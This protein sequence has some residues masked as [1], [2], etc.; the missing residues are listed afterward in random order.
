MPP[1]GQDPFLGLIFMETGDTGRGTETPGEEEC[2]ASVA[3]P[4]LHVMILFVSGKIQAK[5]LSS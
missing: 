1:P 2:G 5:P 4:Y 3:N